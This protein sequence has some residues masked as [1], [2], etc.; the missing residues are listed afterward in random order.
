MR[1]FREGRFDVLV[2]TDIAARGID[3]A[4][5]SHVINFDVPNTPDAYTHRVGRTGRA[6]RQGRAITLVGEEDHGAV[7]DIERKLGGIARLH[8]P[9]FDMPSI[10]ANAPRSHP[11]RRPE[12]NGFTPRSAKPPFPRQRRQR[13]GAGGLAGRT[14]SRSWS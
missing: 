6:E 14:S 9:G 3:V 4:N 1:G 5:I 7:R 12:R 11:A 8:V 10:Q 13:A 2:A